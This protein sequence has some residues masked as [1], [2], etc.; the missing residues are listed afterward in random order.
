[1]S[2]DAARQSAGPYSGLCFSIGLISL[3]AAVLGFAGVPVVIML[4]PI[5][6]GIA[7]VYGVTGWAKGDVNARCI[8]GL[9]AGAVSLLAPLA[10]LFS[11][12]SP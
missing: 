5:G 1:M 12:A 6:G 3:V 10:I 2:A 11:V 7:L 8:V 4:A 9:M